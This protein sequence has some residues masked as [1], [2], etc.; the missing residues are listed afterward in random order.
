MVSGEHQLSRDKAREG[1]REIRLVDY[2]RKK[3]IGITWWPFLAPTEESTRRREIEVWLVT[4]FSFSHDFHLDSTTY[5]IHFISSFSQ[6]VEHV[7]HAKGH[8]WVVLPLLQ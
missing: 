5:T 3:K 6:S 4:Q 7:S 1:Y 2:E 8:G